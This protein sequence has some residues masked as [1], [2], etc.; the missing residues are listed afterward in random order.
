[1]STGPWE[2]GC[3]LYRVFDLIG[4]SALGPTQGLLSRI[5][6]FRLPYILA[7]KMVARYMLTLRLWLVRV[8]I[9]M[10]FSKKIKK[11]RIK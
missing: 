3:Y 6:N 10:F 11:I 4:N 2:L 5:V 1:M 7:A 9:Y 8:G